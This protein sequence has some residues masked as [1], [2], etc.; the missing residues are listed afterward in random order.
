[1]ISEFGDFWNYIWRLPLSSVI[2]EPGVRTATHSE[3][4]LNTRESLARLAAL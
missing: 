3:R 4:E 1:M 2:N